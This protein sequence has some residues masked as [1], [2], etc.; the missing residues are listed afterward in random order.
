MFGYHVVYVSIPGYYVW[1]VQFVWILDIWI[2]CLDTPYLDICCLVQ[3][4]FGNYAVCVSIYTWPRCREGCMNYACS[5]QTEVH[6]CADD[7]A[8]CV[9][10]YIY[11]YATTTITITINITIT[12]HSSAQLSTAQHSTAKYNSAQHIAL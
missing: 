10:I 4:M 8:P 1:I 11:I 9:Y 7:L 6:R 3:F 5:I 12:K 2:S